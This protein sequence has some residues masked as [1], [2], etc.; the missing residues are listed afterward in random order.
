MKNRLAWCCR[1]HMNGLRLQ[2]KCLVELLGLH[3]V[4]ELLYTDYEMSFVQTWNEDPRMTFEMWKRKQGTIP[5]LEAFNEI[6]AWKQEKHFPNSTGL[7]A[8]F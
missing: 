8:I 4:T 2:A 7:L 3:N 6:A 1:R 5:G